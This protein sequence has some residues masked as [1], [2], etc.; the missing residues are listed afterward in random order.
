M[1][2]GMR[3]VITALFPAR[4][5]GT[6]S[7][8]VLP[9]LSSCSPT[10]FQKQTSLSWVRREKENKAR[11]CLCF[12]EGSSVVSSLLGNSEYGVFFLA[13][14]LRIFSCGSLFCFL[15]FSFT[16]HRST[17]PR[18]TDP[19][20]VCCHVVMFINGCRNTRVLHCFCYR[21]LPY[22]RTQ[23]SPITRRRRD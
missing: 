16:D 13:S 15:R 6:I 21:A 3:T 10:A 9:S 8:R 1:L 18:S 19:E 7:T 4:P 5:G 14:L 12:V 2:R 22:V 11:L 17:E 23:P 20:T